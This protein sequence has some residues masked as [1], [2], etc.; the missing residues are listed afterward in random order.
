MSSIEQKTELFLLPPDILGFIVNHISSS[1]VYHLICCGDQQL[2]QKLGAFGV[3]AFFNSDIYIWKIC[4]SYLPFLQE[5]RISPPNTHLDPS[6]IIHSDDISLL[7]SISLPTTLTK[8]TVFG[9][10]DSWLRTLGPNRSRAPYRSLSDILPSLVTFSSDLTIS[11]EH[12]DWIS[13]WPETLTSLRFSG[14]FAPLPRHILH[15]SLSTI[16]DE[17]LRAADTLAILPDE[18]ESFMVE[19][20][21]KT[22]NPNLIRRFLE[23]VPFSLVSLHLPNLMSHIDLKCLPETLTSLH[24][25]TARD[26]N[27]NS[28]F[29]WPPALIE[30]TIGPVSLN[31]WSK[32]PPTL[33]SLTIDFGN[34][35]HT[36]ESLEAQ[37]RLSQLPSSITFLELI[38]APILYLPYSTITFPANL[39]TLHMPTLTLSVYSASLDLLSL[40]DLSLNEVDL[41]FVYKLPQ[42]LTKLA[43]GR[44]RLTA[45][46][47]GILPKSLTYLSG[48]VIT[49]YPPLP[50][51]HFQLNP[52]K[53]VFPPE[54]EWIQAAQSKYAVSLPPQLT[55]L[56]FENAHQLKDDFV[57]LIPS[58][59]RELSLPDDMS[60]TDDGIRALPPSLQ[61]L[62]LSSAEN[63][64]SSSF[65]HL[66][67][68]LTELDLAK[69]AIAKPEDFGDLPSRLSSLEIRA[70]PDASVS[71]FPQS[72]TS[73][74]VCSEYGISEHMQSMLPKHI[75]LSVHVT[76]A[77]H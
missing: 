53:E 22:R 20:E 30:A 21:L 44:L 7:A 5:L 74:R 39:R 64:T 49:P 34:V 17:F 57:R 9:Q 28:E 1:N 77:P 6:Q 19:D 46:I 60:I 66:P 35:G 71:L 51:A 47:L 59:L 76:A 4:H 65:K 41:G 75:R 15:L 14:V 58:T 40:T 13:S 62:R 25:R 18:L 12:M 70:I 50:G 69:L 27:Q 67:R 10:N 24:W 63:I 45:R 72:L 32:F 61:V 48:H 56:H 8:L 29:P 11:L 68:Q 23:S 37:Q 43:I 52:P 2:T 73:L 54:M 42:T 33:K 55:Y 38:A 31:Q 3:V 36:L 26:P 16:D